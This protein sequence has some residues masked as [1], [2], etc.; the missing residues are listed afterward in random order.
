MKKTIHIAAA[1]LLLAS[2]AKETV[3]EPQTIQ[4]QFNLPGTRATASAFEAN[5]AIS[6]YAVE[7]NGTTQMPLQVGG[8]FLNNEKLTYNGTT[9][10]PERTL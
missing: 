5:D 9:W 6:L 1:L 10:T 7:W 4:F 2:C 8:N 3:Q